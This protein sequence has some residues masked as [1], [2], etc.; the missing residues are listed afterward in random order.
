MSELASQ[1]V[2]KK[3]SFASNGTSN[4][5]FKDSGMR[6]MRSSTSVCASTRPACSKTAVICVPPVFT[7]VDGLKLRMRCDTT[8]KDVPTTAL[9]SIAALHATASMFVFWLMF[10]VAL[11]T[12]PVYD[13]LLDVVAH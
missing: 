3:P 1:F 8:E 12:L 4:F 5:S 9:V 6:N 11:Y 13:T 7:P 10:S 2:L